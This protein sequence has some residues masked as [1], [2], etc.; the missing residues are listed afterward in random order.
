M[1]RTPDFILYAQHGWADTHRAIAQ[2]ANSLA[3]SNTL[4]IAPDLGYWK[5]WLRIDPLIERVEQNAIETLNRYPHTPIKIIGHSMGGLIWLEILDRHPQW[6][7]KIHSLVLVASPVGGADLARIFDPLG[8]GIGIARDLGTNRRKLAEK[9]ARSIPTLAIA[10]DKDGGSDGTIPVESTKFFYANFTSV[11]GI[12][13]AALKNHPALV[14]IIRDFWTNPGIGTA[15]SGDFSDT[16][17]ERL[18][19]VSGMTDAHRRYFERAKPHL[20]FKNGISIRIWKNPLQIIHVFLAS[21]EGDCLYSGFVGYLHE[22]RFYQ[23]LDKIGKDY[24]Q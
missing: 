6:W 1:D 3:T 18:R 21:R 7:T 19:S 2:L 11:A 10:G 16:L 9:I 12:S 13:H 22:R 24:S 5:T 14:P 20:V 23:S 4:A 15:P 17:I 8:M